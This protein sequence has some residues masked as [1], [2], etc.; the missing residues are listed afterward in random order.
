[1]KCN[2][3]VRATRQANSTKTASESESCR[4]ITRHEYFDRIQQL[5]S[6]N[7]NRLCT[8]LRGIDQKLQASRAIAASILQRKLTRGF[9]AASLANKHN[10]LML[11][12]CSYNG[13][14]VLVNRQSLSSRE[15]RT[16]AFEGMTGGHADFAATA[17][18]RAREHTQFS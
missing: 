13:V 14:S 11:S 8:Q 15:Q 12:T 5:Y 10:R 4:A 7:C 16:L 3:D 1:M 9:A 18:V 2:A 6:L 17:P